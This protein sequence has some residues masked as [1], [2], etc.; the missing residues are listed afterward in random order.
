[1][2]HALFIQTRKEVR[3]LLPWTIGVGIA[4]VAFGFFASQN[5]GLPGFRQDPGGLFIMAYALGVLSLAALSVGQ[6]L[7]H[8]TL[9]ALLVQPLD[10]LKVLRLKLI[11]LAIPMIGL[12][13]MADAVF[14]HG[15]LPEARR[16]LIWGPVAA[17]LGLVPLL[18]ILTR[19]PLGGVVFAITIPGLFLM[20][21][22]RIW[23][24]QDQALTFTWYCTLAASAIGLAALF[25]QFRRLEVAGDGRQRAKVVSAVQA[26]DVP[27]APYQPTV[28]RSWVWLLIKKELRLQQMTF[29][30]SGLYVLAAVAVMLLAYENPKYMGP[31]F[32]AVS[33]I[34]AYF[35]PLMAGA[36][37]S[38]EERHMGTLAAQ[39]LLP[40]NMRLQWAIKVTITIGIALVLTIGLPAILMATHRPVDAFHNFRYNLDLSV[41]L[42]MMCAAAMYIS[43]LS[44][45]SLWALLGCFPVLGAAAIAGSAGRQLIYRLIWEWFPLPRQFSEP[46]R[47]LNKALM[48][49]E[50]WVKGWMQARNAAV[51]DMQFSLEIVQ[52]SL[53]VGFGLLILYFAARN[54][55]S[56]DRNFRT[57]GFQVLLLLLF[58]TVAA[59]GFYALSTFAWRSFR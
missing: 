49:K 36:M 41:G 45:N 40:R 18:T 39:V 33:M 51:Q 31:S 21:G 56:I 48:A 53:I 27:L 5:A 46:W 23:P 15:Y 47:T 26:S 57:V 42:A 38:A 28:R 2:S 16:L 35:L 14:P 22:T 24:L 17:G 44:A 9:P 54:H 13:L 7:M 10:R 6:E 50:S 37:S 32:G 55:R 3:A 43:S 25:L 19:R 58:T 12:G 1:M 11:V 34:H 20:V 30:V 59:A 4:S 8:G 29:A 52:N